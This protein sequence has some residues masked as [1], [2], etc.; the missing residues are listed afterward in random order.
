MTSVEDRRQRRRFASERQ[1][2][3]HVDP[4]WSE[5]LLLELRLQGVSGAR[6]G[7]VL[8]EVDSHVAES[9]EPAAEAF[10]HPVAY[11]RSL[12][13]P[14]D[15]NQSPAAIA[16]DVAAAAPQ[17]LAFPPAVLG[18]AALDSDQPLGI[19][20]GM[21]VVVLVVVAGLV[22]LARSGEAVLRLA[23]R[24][25][26]LAVLAVIGLTA[27]MVGALFLLDG[28]LTTV[29][30]GAA[31]GLGVALML[32]GTG[33]EAVRR[34]RTGSG[35]DPLV[36]PLGEAEPPSRGA[37]VLTALGTWLAPLVF[38]AMLAAAW[39]LPG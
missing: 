31:V 36:P 28:V 2:A 16:G 23:V 30:A 10:G 22:V 29:P 1:L 25:P 37:T 18:L 17:A 12:K 21:V 34:R 26:V 6:I 27:L 9:G 33:A 19:T 20:V 11:A 8:A 38:V 24:R 13:L 3:P 7:A 39:L 14:P 4:A 35:A 32:G 5:E 15:E